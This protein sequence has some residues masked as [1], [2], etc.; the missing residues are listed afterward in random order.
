M[1]PGNDRLGIKHELHTQR[2]FGLAIHIFAVC[3]LARELLFGRT[4]RSTPPL[5]GP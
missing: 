4:Q 3:A 1:H 2:V 5:T